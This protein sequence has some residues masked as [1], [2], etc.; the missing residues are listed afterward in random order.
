MKIIQLIIIELLYTTESP[1]IISRQ[2]G[3]SATKIT[4]T[5]NTSWQVFKI[6]H[7][8]LHGICFLNFFFYILKVEISVKVVS[9]QWNYPPT[10]SYYKSKYKMVGVLP[11]RIV[12]SNVSRIGP[13]SE[14][15][16]K[17]FSVSLWRGANTR[18]V[19]LYYPHWQYT[20]LFIFRFVSLLML[21]T[22]QHTTF[23]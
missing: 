7:V 19:R 2:W 4:L 8:Y 9:S 15:N 1:S 12:Q 5:F 13:S 17:H 23:I 22:T 11:I 21:R 18:N 20:D 3:T 6:I 10:F 14:R 16:R